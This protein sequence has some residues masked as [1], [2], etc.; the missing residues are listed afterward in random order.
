MA[1][2]GGAAVR[3]CIVAKVLLRSTLAWRLAPERNPRGAAAQSGPAR[4]TRPHAAALGAV[5]R[6]A[7]PQR[8]AS[9]CADEAAEHFLHQQSARKCSRASAPAA[10]GGDRGCAARLPDRSE[11]TW[12]H[13][14]QVSHRPRKWLVI[15]STRGMPQGM[16]ANV[17]PNE[18]GQSRQGVGH[19]GGSDVKMEGSGAK[20]RVWWRVHLLSFCDSERLS[21]PST[22][23]TPSIPSTLSKI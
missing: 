4:A 9:R 17:R 19:G 12:D 14:H 10:V 11:K 20:W 18:V 15:P 1:L 6:Y 13:L 8:K 16:G 21:E 23:S 22:P 3:S 5:V 2:H 7:P